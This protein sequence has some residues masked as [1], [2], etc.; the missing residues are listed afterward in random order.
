MRAACRQVFKIYALLGTVG[1]ATSRDLTQLQFHRFAKD[2]GLLSGEG[3]SKASGRRK[4][5]TPLGG[6]EA[7]LAPHRIA[8]VRA[9]ARG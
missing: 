3:G 2:S 8:P 5:L 6:N 4:H 1:A 9:E 7:L